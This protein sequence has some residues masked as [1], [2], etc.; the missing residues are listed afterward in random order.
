MNPLE[1]NF[2]LYKVV[3]GKRVQLASADVEASAGKW[4][5]LQVVHKGDQIRCI[6]NDK[7][8]LEAK[9]DQFNDAGKI[10]LWTKADAVTYF[11]DLRVGP[12]E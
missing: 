4:H 3:K 2:R 1:S 7:T 12:A 6:F 11:D 10:G 9:D 8:K 5:T